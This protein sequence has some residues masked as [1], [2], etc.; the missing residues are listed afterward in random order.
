MRIQVKLLPDWSTLANPDGPPT[1][2]RQTSEDSGA[3]QVSWAEYAGGRIPN[4]SSE[5]LTQMCEDFGV[6]KQLGDVLE[7]DAG[8]CDYGLF[9]SA[10]FRSEEAPR[11]QI[12]I[13]SDGK[14]FI[15]ATHICGGKID[16]KEVEEAKQIA[17]MLTLKE[18]V[19]ASKPWWKFWR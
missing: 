11:F 8:V 1:Y 19:A 18:E 7:R 6:K 13:I 12:W 17:T 15:H 3:F 2:V 9:G 14:N 10:V 5:S 4:P 16:P